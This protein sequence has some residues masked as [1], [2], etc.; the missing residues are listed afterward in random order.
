MRELDCM[1]LFEYGFND[2][3]LEQIYDEYNKKLADE[4]KLSI[5]KLEK[6]VNATLSDTK[7]ILTIIFY[8]SLCLFLFYVLIKYNK[9]KN[10]K[11]KKK[12]SKKDN[13]YRFKLF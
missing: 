4:K 8:I 11:K 9:R 2:C 7:N 6:T 13:I 12:K 1:S 3:C 10:K 5:Y